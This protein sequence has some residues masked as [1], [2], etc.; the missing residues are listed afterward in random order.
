MVGLDSVKEAVSQVKHRDE[1]FYRIEFLKDVVSNTPSLYNYMGASYFSSTAIVKVTDLMEKLGMRPSSAWYIY[2]G[3]TP[4]IN[5]M[6]SIRYL[7]DDEDVYENR[8]YPNVDMIN[9]INVYENPYQLPL[10][11]VVNERVKDWDLTSE[12]VFLIQNDFVKK[13]AGIEKDLLTPLEIVDK[14]F[15]NLE[16]TDREDARYKY[17]LL[18]PSARGMVNFSIENPDRKLVYLYLKSRQVNYVWYIKNGE[19]EGHDIRY[20]P[21]IIDTQYYG[22]SDSIEISLRV[23]DDRSGEFSVYAYG[24]NEE[25]FYETYEE[26]AA[27][28][29]TLYSFGDT[30]LLGSVDAGE[31]GVLFTSI[32]FDKGWSVKVNGQQRPLS[33]IA[34]GLISIDLTPGLHAIE[35]SF[36]PQGFREGLI[37]TALSLV[38]LVVVVIIGWRRRKI[39]IRSRYRAVY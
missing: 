11:F 1:G 16:I 19:S 18:N 10:G 37:A 9:G 20:Y 26:L 39:Q 27:R 38:V 3:S 28:P 14:S 35:F 30:R 12:N 23:D 29:L 31:G 21:Y 33:S 24:F 34:D 32:P 8:L 7:L 4:L 2:K 17:S 25:V 5:S 6:L 36:T 13:A 22:D 15:E